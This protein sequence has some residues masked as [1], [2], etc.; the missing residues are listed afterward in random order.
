MRRVLVPFP[1][2]APLLWRVALCGA[3]AL[4]AACGWTG[5]EDKDVGGE[6]GAPTGVTAQAGSATSVH[7]MW[8]VTARADVYEVY[9]GTTKVREVPGPTHM[10]DVTRLRPSTLYVFT[11]RARDADG[12]LGPPSR[13]VRARTPAAVADDRSAPTRPS[14]PGG[15][16][17]G[18]RAV[19]LSWSAS[20]DD[21]DV[22]SYDIHQGAA[23]IHSVS[24]D[25]TAAVVTGLRP[26]T[27]YAFT[28]RARDAAGNVSPA[29]T[30]VRL[31]TPGTDDGR[32]TAPTGF[33]ATTH[34]EDGAYHVDLSWVPPRVDGEITE[35]QI[36]LDGRPATSLV[37]GGSAPRERATH[38]FYVGQDAGITHRVRLRAMLPDGTWGG[39]S[40]E[41]KV[42][43]GTRRQ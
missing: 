24:G 6:P 19:Q 26:G 25:Q 21:R 18:S 38:S 27:S 22:V 13:Q 3:L 29:S 20:T 5:A 8:N 39:F 15:R 17:A 9:R 43:T 4:L 35:Y 30:A 11:V 42:T 16:A 2:P 1:A 14:A 10:V 28:V 33:R 7:V 12:R 41:R 37:Y 23:K 36:Q 34:R 32:A 40:A 31:T